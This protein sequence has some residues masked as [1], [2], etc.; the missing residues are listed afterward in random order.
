MATIVITGANR[1]IGLALARQYSA[2]GDV[3]VGVCRHASDELA[4]CA[5]RVIDG[6]DVT[7]DE[8]RR[9]LRA[10]LEGTRID[11]L[12]NNA[13]LLVADDWQHVE[14]EA[15]MQQFVTNAAA[16]LLVTLALQP[17]MVRGGKVGIISSRMGSMTDNASGG[18]YGYRMSKAA[19]NASGVS[20][21]R[22]LQEFE[23]AVALLHPGYVRTRM[24]GGQGNVTAEE[25]AAGLMSRMDDLSLETSGRFWHAN[26]S[27]LP[28]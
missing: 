9:R 2:R 23:I 12:M 10:A 26:G 5:H 22:D 1:G 27:E 3:V 21:A 24:T 20:L 4:A 6:I 14:Q 15:L 19:A 17:L 11:V 18:F 8:H 25:A 28:W 7:L 16:P 13:G